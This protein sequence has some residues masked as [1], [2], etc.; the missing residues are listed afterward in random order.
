MPDYLVIVIFL[1]VS[2]FIPISMLLFS[3]L[4]RPKSDENEVKTLT[5]ESAE[6]SIGQ[7]V[8]VMTEYM[9]YFSLFLTFEIVGVVLIVWTTFAKQLSVMTSLYILM[10]PVFAFVLEGFL[11][12]LNKRKL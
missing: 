11:L 7:R 12:M 10:L 1:A 8:G 2:L 3:R 5:Y 9:P 4:V 6:E